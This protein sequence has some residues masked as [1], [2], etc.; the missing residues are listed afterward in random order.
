M[1]TEIQVLDKLKDLIINN[2]SGYYQENNLPLIDES[3]IK[4]DFPDTDNMRKNTMFYIQP[5]YETFEQLSLNSDIAKMD[6]SLFILTKGAKTEE[7]I[8]RVFAYYTAF[9]KML[10]KDQT[11]DGFV[12]YTRITDMDYFPHI[13]EVANISAIEVRMQI[14]WANEF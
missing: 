8:R 12:D 10:R 3:C 2:L 11:L 14:E 5:D 1:K 9:Y 4:V 13:S 6:V 7:L